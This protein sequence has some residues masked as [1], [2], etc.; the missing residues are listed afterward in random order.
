MSFNGIRKKHKVNI[1]TL[2][3]SKNTVDSEVVMGQLKKNNFEVVIR[4]QDAETIV[5]G[6]L[7]GRDAP[8]I[9]VQSPI[10]TPTS[11]ASFDADVLTF[12]TRLVVGA[13]VADHRWITGSLQ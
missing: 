4:P 11:G 1:I 5:V 9:F 13:K 2:G 12:K 7:N 6:F 10:D 3:C 8:D